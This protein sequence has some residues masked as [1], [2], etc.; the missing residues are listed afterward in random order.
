MARQIKYCR[1]LY[2]FDA[3]NKGELSFKEH[4]II[5]VVRTKTPSGVDDGW[6]EGVM[7]GT[8]GLFPSNYV[9]P[10]M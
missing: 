2:D 1:A 7:D 4:E 8:T 9:E 5:K 3:S 10:C 6:W